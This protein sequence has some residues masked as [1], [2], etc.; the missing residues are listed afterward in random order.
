MRGDLRLDF[1]DIQERAVPSQLQLR[2]N[3]TVRGI[4][5]I[6]LPEGPI[7]G[8]ACSL[9]IAGERLANL[10][11]PVDRLRL[12]FNRRRDRSWLNDLQE[13]FFDRVIDPQAA[14]SDAT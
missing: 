6:V 3:E 9:Q 11:A 7:G 4:G 5:G 8:V 10:V 12:G 13:R 14:E 2:C 1:L